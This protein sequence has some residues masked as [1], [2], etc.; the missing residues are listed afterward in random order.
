VLVYL[1]LDGAPWTAWDAHY[2]PGPETP[3]SR[4]SEPRNYRSS[5]A[6]PPD[7][8]VLCAEIPCEPGDDIW[9]ASVDD[10]GR[11]VSDGLAAVGLPPV[12]PQ[13]IVARRLPAA[14]PIYEP[15]FEA[16]LA[17]L[18]TWASAQ[19]VVS[20]GRGGLFAHDNT[21]HALAEGFAAAA[22]LGTDGIWDAVRW[23]MARRRFADHVVE[24]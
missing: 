11:L 18:E 24:D 9:T 16:A 5:A 13:Q 22:C 8:T 20:F 4:I 17:P 14:Y 15:G 3:V 10:V 1:V 7:R 19:R 21:H 6:D 2:L 23:E 12:E